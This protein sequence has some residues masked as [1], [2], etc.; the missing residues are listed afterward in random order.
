METD[1]RYGID[2]DDDFSGNSRDI[3]KI[4]KVTFIFQYFQI[5]T[6][7]KKLQATYYFFNWK[8]YYFY[9]L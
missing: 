1:F 2:E 7:V 3:L 5:T 9:F 6:K 4:Q 8:S